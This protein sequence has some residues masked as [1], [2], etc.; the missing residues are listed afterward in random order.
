[1]VQCGHRAMSKQNRQ[2]ISIRLWSW[3]MIFSLSLRA[4]QPRSGCSCRQRSK[5]LLPLLRAQLSRREKGS[6]FVV[7]T[8]SDRHWRL[9]AVLQPQFLVRL[10]QVENG[11]PIFLAVWFHDYF[12]L[13]CGVCLNGVGVRQFINM[14]CVCIS[15]HYVARHQKTPEHCVKQH[16]LLTGEDVFWGHTLVAVF[17][18]SSTSY[19]DRQR[20]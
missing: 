17:S 20:A 4:Y 11:I 2:I 5:S 15:L 9:L 8:A 12:L 14:C 16:E 7:A 10:A 3:L 18:C 19:R 13:Y 6:L 1:M